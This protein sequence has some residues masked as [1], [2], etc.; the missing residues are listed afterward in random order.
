M[1]TWQEQIACPNCNSPATV[2]W[3]NVEGEGQVLRQWIAYR[4][5]DAACY[6]T[7]REGSDGA[8]EA[9]EERH[10]IKAK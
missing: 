2:T 10:G 6:E 4:S 8:W 1:A 7:D 5:C 9:Y 3:A